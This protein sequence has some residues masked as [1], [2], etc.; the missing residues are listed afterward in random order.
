MRPAE[1]CGDLPTRPSPLSSPHSPLTLA[2]PHWS[3][4]SPLFSD[5]P[6]ALRFLRLGLRCLDR[7]VLRFLLFRGRRLVFHLAHLLAGERV[8]VDLVDAGLAVGREVEGI[9][10]LAI[11]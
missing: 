7:I 10:Q 2:T 8:D 9:D 1:R 6:S 11:F 4:H 3:R 5:L